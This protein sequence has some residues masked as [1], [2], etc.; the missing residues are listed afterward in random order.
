MNLGIKN[1]LKNAKCT[2][3]QK[4]KLDEQT[5]KHQV[6]SIV[7]LHATALVDGANKANT[8][9][10]DLNVDSIGD[11]QVCTMHYIRTMKRDEKSWMEEIKL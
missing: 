9:T 10:T 5:A 8:V 6:E 4:D 3:H 2:Q 11:R 7:L 1:T